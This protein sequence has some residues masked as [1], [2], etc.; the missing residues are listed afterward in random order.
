M[1][2]TDLMPWRSRELGA[3]PANGESLA[4]FR[5]EM[6]RLFDDFLADPWGTEAGKTFAPKL[7]ITETEGTIEVKAE[8]P[9]VDENDVE[10][11]LDDASLTIRG[12]KKEEKETEDEGWHVRESSYGKF[13]RVVPLPCG[14]D[15][16]KAKARHKKGVLTITLPKSEDAKKARKRIPVS[17]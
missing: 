11:L 12:E 13:E 5:R 8:I 14:V 3:R 4:S 7:D 2:L 9:G 17:G 1:K 6:N 10:L 15:S 16:G